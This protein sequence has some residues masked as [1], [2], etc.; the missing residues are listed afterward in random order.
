MINASDVD[1][2]PERVTEQELLEALE[3]R[4]P[5]IRPVA[6]LKELQQRKSPRIGPILLRVLGDRK[7]AADLRTAAAVELGKEAKA[8]NRQA[9]AAAI[10]PQDSETLKH[11]A[12]LAGTDR[13]RGFS[14]ST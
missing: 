5:Q 10:D 14:A 3:G 2:I 12:A 13:R 7:L 11:V 4:L 6:A 9:L 8:E 1:L